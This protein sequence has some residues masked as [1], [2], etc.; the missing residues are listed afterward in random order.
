MPPAEAVPFALRVVV[1]TA[2]ANA[3]RLS[4]VW[5]TVV[6]HLTVVAGHRSPPLRAFAVDAFRAIAKELIESEASHNKKLQDL[7]SSEVG[8]GGPGKRTS[9]SEAEKELAAAAAAARTYRARFARMLQGW[10]LP[11]GW[12][13]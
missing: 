9:T 5:P 6:A 4:L 7:S 2:V 11:T 12:T 3:H 10:L 8:V 1:A 13:G